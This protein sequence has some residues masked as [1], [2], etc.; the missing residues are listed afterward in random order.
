LIKSR[1]ASWESAQIFAGQ[2]E[3]DGGTVRRGLPLL[4]LPVL[5]QGE[6]LLSGAE[7]ASDFF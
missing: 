2:N 3:A 7:V 1:S 5:G 6:A 4:M